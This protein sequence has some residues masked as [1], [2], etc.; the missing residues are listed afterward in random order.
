[1][2]TLFFLVS[3]SSI[4]CYLNLSGRASFPQCIGHVS[5]EETKS[6]SALASLEQRAFD[7]LTLLEF[8]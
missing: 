8:E 2:A 6:Q 5:K 4:H 3:G 1:M 7:R